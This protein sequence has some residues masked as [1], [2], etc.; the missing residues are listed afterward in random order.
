[1]KAN[2]SM[3]KNA[4]VL[5][6]QASLK[7]AELDYDSYRNLTKSNKKWSQL[8]TAP[9]LTP[10]GEGLIHSIMD[11]QELYSVKR[12]REREF[13]VF[14]SDCVEPFM[15]DP[16]TSEDRS[17]IPRFHRVRRVVVDA[18]GVC[19]CSCC[20]FER[21]G[22]PCP[23]IA[24]VFEAL[25]LE[26][27]LN[28]DGFL[29]TDVAVRWWS[30]YHFS[31]YRFPGHGKLTQVFHNLRKNDVKGPKIPPDLLCM[32]WTMP[33]QDPSPV[34][35]AV[36]RL[37]NY[38]ANDVSSQLGGTVDGCIVATYFPECQLDEV[39]MERSMLSVDTSGMPTAARNLVR[40]AAPFAESIQDVD[41]GADGAMPKG[42]DSYN[43]LIDQFRKACAVCDKYPHLRGELAEII[44]KVNRS[45]RKEDSEKQPD[46]ERNGGTVSFLTER[47]TG[48]SRIFNTINNP[49][50]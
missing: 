17:P 21:V 9:Y 8:P 30:Q 22:I 27:K 38:D 25:H 29:H 7:A 41:F 50:M 11:R 44:E 2:A 48:P 23:H 15:S 28:W 12:V 40:D 32:E 45:G 16:S 46:S 35:S 33:I 14:C 10:F 3:T 31:A 6:M 47:Q 34:K 18:N 36:S 19:S 13:E 4:K 43:T 39:A 1:M 42:V 24:Q 37:K 49:S 20:Y 5:S 26:L